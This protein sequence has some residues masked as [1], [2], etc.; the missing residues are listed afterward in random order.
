LFAIA[1]GSLL[2]AVVGGVYSVWASRLDL[3]RVQQ[4]RERSTV[5]DRDGKPYGRLAGDENRL[6]VPLSKVSPLFINAL[7]A[8][9][10]SRFYKHL[11]VDPFGIVRA[12]LRNLV[13]RSAA[14]GASTLTQQLARNS[15]PLGGK[16]LHRK[17]LEA[18]VA[19]RME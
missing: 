12:A 19:V 6:V 11:G 16:N 1:W 4:I 7:L 3:A 18:F 15:F 13:S 10:D 2:C 17:I 14:Q 9:E 8:R 5:F